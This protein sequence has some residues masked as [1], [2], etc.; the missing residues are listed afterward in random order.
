M[1]GPLPLASA[2]SDPGRPTVPGDRRRHVAHLTVVHRPDDTRIYHRECRSLA[3]AGYRVSLVA[4]GARSV[5]GSEVRL[6]AI[7]GFAHRLARGRR[8]LWGHPAMLARAFRLRADLY[9]VHDPELLGVA[10]VLKGLRRARVVYDVHEDYRVR[11]GSREWLPGPLRGV[12]ARGVGAWDRVL[13]PR[14]DGIVAVS[15]RIARWYPAD[16]TVVVRNYPLPPAT[17]G[18]PPPETPRDTAVVLYTGGVTAFGG[19]TQ[20]VR[21]LELAATPGIRLVVLGGHRDSGAARDL[22]AS[23]AARRVEVLGHVPLEEV[24]RWMT[25]AAL[26]VVCN[27]RVHGYDTAEPTK[28]YEYMAAGLPVIASDS[29]A[30]SGVVE[31]TGCGVTVDPAQPAAIAAALDRLLGDAA[32]RA[33]MG[34]RGRRAVA[35]HFT[36]ESQAAVLRDL[37]QRLIGPPGA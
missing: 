34:E 29:P 17:L 1:G 32:L 15:E 26:G 31:Q 27:Q 2:S 13:A 25:R 19:L 14:A 35:E 37:Y 5:P 18:S 10:A 24:Y 21:A 3:A 28:L 12:A 11:L 23:P 7:P 20:V 4:P 30:W 36:W 9:H 33:T 6:L 16:R 8:L 22:A